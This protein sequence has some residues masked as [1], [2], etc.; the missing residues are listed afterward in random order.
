VTGAI[1]FVAALG[2]IHG[3]ATA[4]SDRHLGRG[5][6]LASDMRRVD[7]QAALLEAEQAYRA[8]LAL[9]GDRATLLLNRALALRELGLRDAAA[10][11]MRR[12]FALLPSPERA[13]FLGDLAADARQPDAAERW[14][15]VA[16]LLHPRYAR[17]YN[18]YGVVLYRRGRTVRGCEVLRRALSLRPY[19]PMIRANWR[20]LCGPRTRAHA[21]AHAQAHAHSHGHAHAPAHAPAKARACPEARPMRQSAPT[22]ASSHRPDHGNPDR[23]PCAA[24]DH[25]R[26]NPRPAGTRPAPE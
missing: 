12:S 26:P 25:G 23:D 13:L 7:R 6:Q 14:Y 15:Q 18:N 4:L 21:R 16:V 2:L 8:G 3:A 5:L 19:E 10:R 22:H 20:L 24:R 9:P 17:A 1:T 11:D